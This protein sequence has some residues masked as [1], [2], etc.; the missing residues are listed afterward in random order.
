MYLGAVCRH[1]KIYAVSRRGKETTVNWR[2]F[3]AWHLSWVLFPPKIRGH[4]LVTASWL[5]A[6]ENYRLP[7]PLMQHVFGHDATRP[8]AEAFVVEKA[9]ADA[10]LPA[11][12]KPPDG[13]RQEYVRCAI[14][15]DMHAHGYNIPEEMSEVLQH[16]FLC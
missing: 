1:G 11:A 4:T 5:T 15:Q 13:Q 12:A 6:P 14:M 2:W 9:Q 8:L 16:L 10:E 3:D 7:K